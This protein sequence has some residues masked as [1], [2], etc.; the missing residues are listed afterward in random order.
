MTAADQSALCVL[1]P[2]RPDRPPRQA[3]IGNACTPCAQ[4]LTNTVLQVRRYAGDLADEPLERDT[5]L[6]PVF[7][8]WGRAVYRAGLPVLRHRDPVAAALPAGP[9]AAA[10]DGARVSGTATPRPPIPVER[11]DL[12][13]DATP[14][15]TEPLTPLVRTWR[16]PGADPIPVTVAGQ[17][18]WVGVWHRATA[19][20]DTG[21]PILVPLGDQ[22]G[23]LPPRVLLE[24]WVIEWRAQRGWRTGD[25]P[26]AHTIDGYAAWLLTRLDW[27]LHEHP[28]LPDFAAEMRTLASR[29][30]TAAGHTEPRPDRERF[31]GV[32]CRNDQCDVRGAL[33]QVPGEDWIE[34]GACG[35]ILT[36]PEYHA[37]VARL[38]AFERHRRRRAS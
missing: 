14:H 2:P 13:G 9:T 17:I 22:I 5:R 34:C 4:R 3:E 8:A 35:L 25:D 11:L 28:A 24:Q 29:L 38:A 16:D 15:V 19:L 23:D 37:W 36:E 27:A 30:R 32:T 26:T 10:A 18:V 31:A 20:D 12:T 1:C 33:Y 21:R 6:I 7:D